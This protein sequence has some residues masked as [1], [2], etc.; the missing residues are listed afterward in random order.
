M[1]Q[2]LLEDLLPGEYDFGKTEW[3]ADLE[4]K[5]TRYRYTLMLTL[6]ASASLIPLIL[7]IGDLAR[8]NADF[9]VNYA[10]PFAFLALLFISLRATKNI[11]VFSM[12][13]MLT[14]MA[15]FVLTLYLPNN[16]NVAILVF[17]CFPPMAF[18][19]YGTKRGARWI[20]VFFASVLLLY[21]LHVSGYGPPWAV[22]LPH[23]NNML[24][25]CIS[26]V[27]ISI[28]TY[29]GGRQHEKNMEI[30]LRSIFYDETTGLP[31]RKAL[32]HYSWKE[33]RYLF[34]IIHIE[35]FSDLGLLFGYD[36]SDEILLFFS[37]QLEKWKPRFNYM[38]FRLK[39]N[40]FG[41]LFPLGD[42][43]RE[44]AL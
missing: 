17:F 34:A 25:G 28:I 8:G 20:A 41:I 27:L 10:V 11:R 36:L 19:L 39:G 4:Q 3:F 38:V 18:Q 7:A 14:C 44:S 29:F 6:I 9:M 15:G 40:E 13:T 35:N 31:N 30:I 26:L 32:S 16:R 24:L 5:Y 33:Q 21:A 22:E 1:I 43:E 12:L 37:R 2:K 42:A 23:A